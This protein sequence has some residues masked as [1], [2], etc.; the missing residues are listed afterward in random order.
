MT[1]DPREREE[2][3]AEARLMSLPGVPKTPQGWWT[4]GLAVL[5]LILAGVLIAWMIG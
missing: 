5:G 2:E 1:R 3:E 4:A